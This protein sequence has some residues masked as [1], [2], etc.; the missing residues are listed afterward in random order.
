MVCELSVDP[1]SDFQ[2]NATTTTTLNDQD[3][4]LSMLT[5][6]DAAADMVGSLRG[7]ATA[8]STNSTSK[9]DYSFT[10]VVFLATTTMMIVVVVGVVLGTRWRKGNAIRRNFT[11]IGDTND[12]DVNKDRDR[13]DDDDAACSHPTLYNSI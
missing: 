5:M 7:P 4:S 2:C 13:N 11:S 9:Q 12:D 8:V 6:S 3:E 10:I 1:P